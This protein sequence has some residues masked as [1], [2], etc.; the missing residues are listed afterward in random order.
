MSAASLE[1][2]VAALETEVALLRAKIEKESTPEA[3]CGRSG[4]ER[5]VGIPTSKR[6]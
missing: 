2:R 6:P 5:F 1:D 3:P 4:S